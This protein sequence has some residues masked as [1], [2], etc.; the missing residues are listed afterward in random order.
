M[1]CILNVC[2]IGMLAWISFFPA[3][4]MDQR[5]HRVAMAIL[6]AG[7]AQMAFLFWRM[8]KAGVV[9]RLS[10]TGWRDAKVV[11]VWRNLGVA[12]LGAGAIQLNY[13]LDQLLAYCASPWAAGVIGY[14]ERLMDLP[15][16]VIG[17]LY[18]SSHNQ[19]AD[20]AALCLKSGNAVILRGGSEAVNSNRIIAKVLTEAA[21]SVGLPD[22][23]IQLLDLTGR[24]FTTALME[25]EDLDVLI[26]RG[27]R[28]LK[29][30]VREH[31]KV[32]Y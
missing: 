28:G 1:P 19:T 31:C 14:A 29:A 26:P 21:L 3:L 18:E 6:V 25:L 17:V 11:L 24:E 10:F 22:G 30:A 9:P 13:L 32:P 7:A 20:T 5:I 12:A 2:W 16:G 15:L 23:C 4:R 8:A 27:G